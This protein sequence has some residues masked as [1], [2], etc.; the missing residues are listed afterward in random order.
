MKIL[1]YSAKDF[2]IPFLEKANSDRYAVKYCTDRLTAKTAMMAIG[3]N[4]ICIFSADEGSSKV[5]ELLWDFGV[6]YIVLRSTGYDNIH[7]RTAEKLGFKVANAPDYSPNAI[8][9]HAV[10]LIQTVNRKIIKAN[11]Q[12]HNYNFLLD[13]LIGFDL[14]KK[15]VGVIGTGK[16]GKLIVKIMYGFGCAILVN[17]IKEDRFLSEKYNAQYVSLEKLYAESDIIVIAAPLNTQTHH[18]INATAINFM[19]KEVIV[20]NI[21]RGAIVKTE[22]IITALERKRIG[23]YA[24]DVYEYENGLFFYDQSKNK[25]VD[26]LLI[27]LI[28]LPNTLITPHQAFATQEALTN[29][30]RTT[31]NTFQNWNLGKSSPYELNQQHIKKTTF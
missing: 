12:V 1:I 30:A 31:F 4:A 22:D 3:F 20:V 10:T 5:L 18:L 2:E 7:L 6:R 14:F 26:E 23:A 15:K 28:N 16:I 17:D 13:D 25:R 19:K 21:A 27:K 29:I 24:T 11:S 9:E 8:A